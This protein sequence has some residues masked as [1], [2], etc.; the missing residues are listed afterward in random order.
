[1]SQ[2]SVEN[3]KIVLEAFMYEHNAKKHAIQDLHDYFQNLFLKYADPRLQ[4]AFELWPQAFAKIIVSTIDVNPTLHSVYVDVCT[5]GL[6]CVMFSASEK[7]RIA[8]LAEACRNEIDN[9][10]AIRIAAQRILAAI[11]NYEELYKEFPLA[12]NALLTVQHRVTGGW[13]RPTDEELAHAKQV[14][15]EYR[16]N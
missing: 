15:K 4:D 5:F 3:K 9:T 6:L 11:E 1:M 12:K 8:D 14:L 2:V 7:S 16:G 13:A 10:L